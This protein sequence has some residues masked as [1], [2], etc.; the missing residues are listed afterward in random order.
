MLLLVYHPQYTRSPDRPTPSKRYGNGDYMDIREPPEAKDILNILLWRAERNETRDLTIHTQGADKLP[1]SMTNSTLTNGILEDDL[2]YK[3]EPV[4][5]SKEFEHILAYL[6]K[7]T[8]KKDMAH[9]T[10]KGTT[11]DE[12][13]MEV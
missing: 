2:L 9:G 1:K 3:E 11:S 6:Q 13:L 4:L 8:G 12:D 10:E 7:Y 5:P